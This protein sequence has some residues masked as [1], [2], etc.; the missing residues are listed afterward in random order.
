[1][2]REIGYLLEQRGHHAE[3][4]AGPATLVGAQ[5]LKSHVHGIGDSAGALGKNYGSGE[6]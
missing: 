3:S 6:R 5:G 4:H 2:R 1:M